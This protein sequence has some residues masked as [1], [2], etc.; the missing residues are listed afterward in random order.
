MYWSDVSEQII[1]ATGIN[2]STDIT[3]L[4]D[5]NVTIPGI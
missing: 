1:V 2:N 5:R 3:I 4:V